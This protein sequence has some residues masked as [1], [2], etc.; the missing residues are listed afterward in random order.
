MKDIFFAKNSTDQKVCRGMWNT[1]RGDDVYGL[2]S[3]YGV[4]SSEGTIY[5]FTVYKQL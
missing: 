4:H 2:L 3:V 1:D 5:S